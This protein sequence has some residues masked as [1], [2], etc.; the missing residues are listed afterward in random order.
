MIE[1]VLIFILFLGP[2]VFFHE[3]GHFLFA[4]LFGVKVQVFSIGFGPKLFKFKKGDTEYALSLIPLGGYVKMFGD[5]PFNGDAIPVEERK[6]SF[7]HKSKWARFWIVFGGP[8]AN[9]IMAY[10][11]FFSLLIGGE[12]MPELK[13]GLVTK[14]SKFANFG[15]KTGDILKEVNGESVSNPSDVVLMD[16]G[17]KTLT[18]ERFGEMKTVNIGMSGEEFFEEMVNYP[19]FLRRPV[20]TSYNGEVFA[21]SLNKD[22]V[23]WGESLDELADHAENQSVYLF[24]M[25][26]DADLGDINIQEE[27]PFVSEVKIGN[28]GMEN[29]FKTMREAK[30]YPNDMFV[31]SISMKSPAEKAGILGGNIILGLNGE[32]IYSF[33]VLRATLQ[34]IETKEVQVKIL[35]DNIEK[36]VSLT[37]DV[38][39]QGEKKVKLIGVY[40]NGVFQGMRFVDTPSKGFVGSFTGAFSRTWDTIVKTVGS[41]KKLIVG[42]VSLKNIGGPLAIGKVASDSFQTSLSYFFQLMALIS[43]NLGVI[44]LFPIPVLDGGHILFLGLEFLNRGPVS[45]RKMEIAQQFGLSMLL[46]LMIGAIF[47]DVVRFF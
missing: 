17:V 31:K 5:D 16:G 29:F 1:K 28:K 47:N 24:K 43:V 36:S 6:Y 3:L 4:R 10:V 38:K 18:V 7:T 20:M 2:L 14:D 15:I 23:N 34:K 25:K 41:F 44:N 13:M 27:R 45:R 32:D 39:P 9:F 37:P 19:P 33:E 26:K 11:I 42:E 40:S 46:M 21:L 8:L 22:S 12:K 30:L 35:A